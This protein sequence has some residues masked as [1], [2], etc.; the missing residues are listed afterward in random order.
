MGRKNVHIHGRR[1][2]A[3]PAAAAIV[4]AKTDYEEIAQSLVRRGLASKQILSGPSA[5]QTNRR[6]N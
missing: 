5:M 2:T 1:L 6:R 3:C 4:G